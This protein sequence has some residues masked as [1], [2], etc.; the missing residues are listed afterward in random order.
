MT[1]FAI[2]GIQMPI[3]ARES[4][5]DAMLERLA[6]CV[7]RFPWVQMV[8]FS[9]LAA[10]G[11]Y[12][13]HAEPVGGPTETAFCKAAAKHGIWVLPGSY[14]EKAPDGKIYNT[15]PAISPAGEVVT[16]C[17]KLFPFLPYEVGVEGGNEVCVFDVP[18][19]G[20][21]GIS[22]CYD[23]WF[24]ETTRMLSA[25]GAEV[26][27]HPVL[28][29]TVDRDVETAIARA[30]A[31]QFQLYVFDINGLG[32]GGVGQSAVIGPTGTTLHNAKTGEEMMP[33][34]IDFDLVRRQRECGL[35]GLGQ[36]L[37]S[38]RDRSA[39]FPI[40]EQG[41]EGPDYSKM[42]GPLAVPARGTNTLAPAPLSLILDKRSA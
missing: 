28:T 37:K 31:A 9:E 39:R 25:L 17:R 11:P 29:G 13:H 32:A 23:I 35:Q 27:L 34:E 41:Y 14:F 20:R 21:I 1:P 19:V 6:I 18:S 33:I 10:H 42:L 2:A 16:R 5:I 38:F 36:P 12:I 24:P 22:I 3:S 8:M 4:N 26:L 40:Y 7:S 15:A 30:T